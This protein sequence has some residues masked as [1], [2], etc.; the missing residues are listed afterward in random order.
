MCS[1]ITIFSSFLSEK[2]CNLLTSVCLQIK[3]AHVM[4]HESV[5]AILTRK[6]ERAGKVCWN[7]KYKLSRHYE[8][9][10][11]YINLIMTVPLIFF[12]LCI[13]SIIQLHVCSEFFFFLT[14]RCC[15]L[16]FFLFLPSS[17]Q[18]SSNSP[19]IIAQ[20]TWDSSTA[21]NSAIHNQL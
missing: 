10:V 21:Q 4:C 2:L 3:C 16:S 20:K 11:I 14:C 12:C 9:R 7:R 6:S 17:C 19:F 1:S 18:S 5:K 8:W 13:F 15:R